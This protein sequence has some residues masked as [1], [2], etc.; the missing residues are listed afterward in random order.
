MISPTKG[1]ILSVLLAA[2]TVLFADHSLY[3][4]SCGAC[5]GADGKGVEGQFPPL[6]ESEWVEGAPD[7][8]IQI[9]LKGITGP[10][11][12]KGK[13]YNLAMPPQGMSMKDQQIAKVLSYVRANFGNKETAITTEMVA[14]ARTQTKK[15][16]K[17][18]SAEELTALYPLPGR[19]PMLQNLVS[20]VYYGKWKSLPDLDKLEPDAVEEEHNGIMSVHRTAKKDHFAMRFSGDFVV[21]TEGTYR[22]TL[23]AD[24]SA[25]LFIAGERIIHL[26]GKGPMNGSRVI[27]KEVA[28]K[29]GRLAFQLDYWE[30]AGQE[31][32][33]VRVEG[34]GVPKD[35]FLT[36]Q[37]KSKKKGRTWESIPIEA[38]DGKVALYRNFIA[39]TSARA[40][41]VGYPEGVNL[42]FSADDFSVGI[43]WRGKFMDAG[44][45]WTDR[46]QGFQ[47]PAGKDVALLGQGPAY[48]LLDSPK[49]KWPK[50]F[51]PE[52]EARFLGYRLLDGTGR[53]EF[54]YK[55]SGIRISDTITPQSDAILRLIQPRSEFD[56][57]QSLHMR[58]AHGAPVK[59]VAEGTYELGETLTI[60]VEGAVTT[61]LP[62]A[63]IITL[64][65]ASPVGITYSW[66]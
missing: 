42:A 64:T 61:V 58:I 24:D 35:T 3:M 45:H 23:D 50:A 51:Q 16:K 53:P 2:S 66:K 11:Q 41:G 5:H 56:S 4:Q 15:R 30:Y 55:V 21:K 62:R 22:F 57:G 13:A 9:V 49:E 18:W 34:P 38:K 65:H 43:I 48:A 54:H 37:T 63:L 36:P 10:I 46:G 28:L 17:P 26:P 31:G 6:A 27:K 25:D 29:P 60:K 20:K 7:R 39:G 52:L 8:L 44:R 12:V 33:S 19:E 1:L 40:I 47:A 59:K 32:L 14:H